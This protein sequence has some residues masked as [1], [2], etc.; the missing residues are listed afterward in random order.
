[1]I[2]IGHLDNDD[3]HGDDHSDNDGNDH[4]QE[5]PPRLLQ[6]HL[7][8]FRI[9]FVSPINWQLIGKL[10]LMIQPRSYQGRL[11]YNNTDKMA[12]DTIT[13]I[14]LCQN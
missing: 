10:L 12:N 11:I 7:R 13:Q 1:M 14:S 2:Y 4:N 6:D 5:T 8:D 9:S 3:D